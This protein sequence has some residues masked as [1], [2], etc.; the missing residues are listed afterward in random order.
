M[1]QALGI[2]TEKFSDSTGSLEG[3][4]V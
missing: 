2:E 1:L 3:F 4:F